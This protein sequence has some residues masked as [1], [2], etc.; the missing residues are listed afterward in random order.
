M[1]FSSV[2]LIPEAEKLMNFSSQDTLVGTVNPLL[3][4]LTETRVDK[5]IYSFFA[6]LIKHTQ[7]LRG[8]AEKQFDGIK[9]WKTHHLDY[10]LQ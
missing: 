4:G 7:N 1:V 3:F 10:W 2:C 8:S 9:T 5:Q 6:F